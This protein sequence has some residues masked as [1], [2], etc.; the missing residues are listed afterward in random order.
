MGTYAAA[1]DAD[2][3]EEIP[4]RGFAEQWLS[5]EIDIPRERGAA[6]NVAAGTARV[7][8][9]QIEVHLVPFF[10]EGDLREIRR[11]DIQRFYDHCIDTGRPRSPKSIDNALN[12]LRM[13]LGH[14]EGQE[15]VDSNPVEGWKR[16]RPRRRASSLATRVERA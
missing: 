3:Q 7:Y 6:D 10:G 2:R 11:R 4:F 15:L 9:L 16:S 8:R 12:V 14:A 5:R 13:V 1:R